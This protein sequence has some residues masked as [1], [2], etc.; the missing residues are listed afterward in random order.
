VVSAGE[1]ADV[2]GFGEDLR[3]VDRP[4]PVDLQQR[5]RVLGEDL[6]DVLLELLESCVQTRKLAGVVQRQLL[7]GFPDRVARPHRSQQRAG[8]GRA[9]I[10]WRAARNQLTQHHVQPV[11]GRDPRLN[12]HTKNV[13]SQFPS[14][15]PGV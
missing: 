14:Y 2:T 13:G 4:D 3:G 15:A 1:S 5:A 7:A 9:Q 12:G 6:G 8:L 11:H 10:A